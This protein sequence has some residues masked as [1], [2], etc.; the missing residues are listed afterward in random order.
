MPDK[1]DYVLL[2]EDPR[3]D[4]FSRHCLAE[5]VLAEDL[6][7]QRR[8]DWT[9]QDAVILINHGETSASQGWPT[10]PRPPSTWDCRPT[11]L[12]KH[13]RLNQKVDFRAVSEDG[14]V[15][16]RS[17]EPELLQPEIASDDNEPWAG[18]SCAPAQLTSDGFKQAV[19]VGRR[20]AWQYGVALSDAV[21]EVLSVDTR[22]SLATA[23]GVLL[24]LLSGPASLSTV[25]DGATLS[26]ITVAGAETLVDVGGQMT[27]VLEEMQSGADILSRWC[28]HGSLPCSP[29][30]CMTP[31]MAAA[32]IARGEARLCRTLISLPFPVRVVGAM[33]STGKSRLS[34]LSVSGVDLSASLAQLL[35]E[36]AC[37][38]ILMIRPPWS[39]V[40]AFVA[41]MPW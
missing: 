16:D 35:G 10:D 28:N 24:P 21:L 23:V 38:D 40:L 6:P 2:S 39:S 9:L 7:D 29:A 30:G 1:S 22:R 4:R 32:T 31:K 3:L 19:L 12:P 17:F 15:L 26:V 18:R 36:E 13:W 14:S 5:M 20:I 34:I 33:Q 27:P 37:E 25:G 11:D 8:T 41:C